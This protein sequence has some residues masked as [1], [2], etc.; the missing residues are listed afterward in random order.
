MAA[1]RD[2]EE[3]YSRFLRRRA[4]LRREKALT[5]RGPL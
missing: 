3:I 2:M 4:L 5:K 1:R